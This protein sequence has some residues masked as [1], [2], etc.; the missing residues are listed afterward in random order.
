MTSYRIFIADAF[1]SVPFRGNQAAVVPVPPDAP[2]NDHL[3]QTV[4]AEMNLSETAFVTPVGQDSSFE[5]SSRFELRWFTPVSEVKLCGH[6]TLATAHA[7]FFEENNTNDTL[8]FDTLSGELTVRRKEDNRLEMAFP[9]DAPEHIEDDENAKVLVAAVL[10]K[11][12]PTIELMISPSLRYMIIYDPDCNETELA[13]L[14][15]A[16]DKNAIEAGNRLLTNAVIVTTR[17]SDRDYKCRVF[18]PWVGID[19]DP[20]TGSA[21][22]VLAPF[23]NSRLGKTSFISQQCSQRVGE[24]QVELVGSHVIVSGQTVVVLRG[25]ISV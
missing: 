3:M 13:S 6:A 9:A 4:A 22:T 18:A 12:K 19:E 25:S 14:A 21:Q 20:V 8:Y 11:Y 2:I 17:G 16:I 15:P 24:L 1:T 10:G 5:T 23:W 7:L